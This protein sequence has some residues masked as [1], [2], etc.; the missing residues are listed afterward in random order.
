MIATRVPIIKDGKIV[1]VVE[2]VLF[3]NLDELNSLTKSD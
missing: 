2:K 1:G 3:K